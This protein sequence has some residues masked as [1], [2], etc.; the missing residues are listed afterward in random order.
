MNSDLRSQASALSALPLALNEMVGAQLVRRSEESENAFLFK[1][2]LVQDTAYASLMRHDRKRL[3][4]L[5]AHALERTYPDRADELAPLLAG[6]FEEAGETERA[7]TYFQRAA[8]NAA[9]QYA[10]REALDFYTRA[11]AAAGDLGTD[12]RDTLYR[13]RGEVHERI[14]NFDAARADLEEALSLAR[15]E[16]DTAAEW[17]SLMALG[18]AWLARD[19]ARAGEYLKKALDLARTSNDGA[20]VAHTL[21]R[22]GNWYLNNEDPE[23]ALEHHREALRAFE[24]SGNTHGIAETQDLLGMTNLV[25]GDFFAARDHFAAALE[26]FGRVGDIHGYLASYMSSF[27]YDTSVQ[28]DTVVLPPPP[29]DIETGLEEMTQLSRQVGWR[30][31]EAY[32]LWILAERLAAHGS[33]GRALELLDQSL[34][35]AR[36][37][38]HRQWLTAG[39]LVQGQ[40]HLEILDTER[41]LNLLENALT[42]AKEIGSIYWMRTISGLLGSACIN[43]GNTTRAKQLLDAALPPGTRARTL[44]QRQA[45]AARVELALALKNPGQA[46]EWLD[47]LLREASNLTPESVI[48]HLWNLRAQAF[49]QQNRLEE[50]ERLLLAAHRTAQAGDQPPLEWRTLSA[51]ARIYRMQGR[52][53]DAQRA[54]NAALEVVERL[55]KTIPIAA[56]RANFSARANARIRGE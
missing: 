42:L 6:H 2:A 41:A 52:P 33:Y 20:R 45:W 48:P 10:N 43:A 35:I 30:A 54:A 27:L 5:V 44:G 28:G 14:G 23:R 37:I 16:G 3:H 40:I 38:D 47:L 56:L 22:V 9:A 55:A 19:Y 26:L 11:I 29:V 15:A 13:A 39:T 46:L 12:T 8:E 36:E 4:G 51:L 31:G 21:N 34:T 25:G 1:H 53:D 7:L 50:A 17:Q 49:L 24:Q 32:G 18:F